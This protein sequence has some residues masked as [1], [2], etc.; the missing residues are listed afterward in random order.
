MLRSQD[1]TSGG[2]VTLPAGRVLVR[3][4]TSDI[5]TN[6]DRRDCYAQGPIVGMVI[7]CGWHRPGEHDSRPISYTAS[8]PCCTINPFFSSAKYAAPEMVI[9]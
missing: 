1:P 9:Q 2:C 6:Q 7:R 4:P 8:K 3:R 5:G